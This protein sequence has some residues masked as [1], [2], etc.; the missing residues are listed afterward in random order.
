MQVPE[1]SIEMALYY[2]TM[3]PRHEVTGNTHL[4]YNCEVACCFNYIKRVNYC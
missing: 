4:L 3:Q 1:T 2:L